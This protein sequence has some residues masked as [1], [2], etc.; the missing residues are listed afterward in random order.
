MKIIKSM[1]LISGLISIIGLWGCGS[2][3]SSSTPEPILK[4]ISLS[5]DYGITPY[6]K[7]N[8]YTKS[9]DSIITHVG[10]KTKV[11]A[12]GYYSDGSVRDITNSAKFKVSQR[13]KA[14]FD[15][16]HFIAKDAGEIEVWGAIGEVE[17]QIYSVKIS[18]SNITSISIAPKS[19]LIS[20]IDGYVV[21]KDSVSE[22]LLMAHFDDDTSQL[23][24]VDDDIEW[25]FDDDFIGKIED[26]K[27]S[28][29]NV[30]SSHL[31]ASF[32]GSTANLRIL[33]NDNENL[34]ELQTELPTELPLFGSA[35]L[36]ISAIYEKDNELLDNLYNSADVLA[37]TEWA[38][39]ERSDEF[40][41][42]VEFSNGK[43][44]AKKE[45]K[46][47]IVAKALGVATVHEM[48]I[49]DPILKEITIVNE[50][51]VD[52]VPHGLTI[53]LKAL[54]EFEGYESLVDVT[55]SV[56]WEV[57]GDSFVS[58]NDGFFKAVLPEGEVDI[59]AKIS[60]TTSKPIKLSATDAAVMSINI[61]ESLDKKTGV[62]SLNMSSHIFKVYAKLSDERE[63]DVTTN[64]KW[65]TSEKATIGIQRDTAIAWF[66][67]ISGESRYTATL[68][69]KR[70]E[71]VIKRINPICED[72]NN[73]RDD[74]IVVLGYGKSRFMSGPV[75]YSIQSMY[76]KA[77]YVV[78]DKVKNDNALYGPL[79]EFGLMSNSQGS[80][81]C[82][83]LA[84]YLW[85]NSELKGQQPTAAEMQDFRGF[86][87][88]AID[89]GLKR[90]TANL[91]FYSGYRSHSNWNW[92]F[93]ND[94][95]EYAVDY[96]NPGKDAT[97]MCQFK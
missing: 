12:K 21:P 72:N 66:G 89:K 60:T 93:V 78:K 42:D 46:V 2:D 37:F 9:A 30:G 50:Q 49:T 11:N 27:F 92:Y 5:L 82:A 35:E 80:D 85:E 15:G 58:L 44:V 38:I 18:D 40:R 71:F 16:N 8:L 67:G 43:L 91:G 26:G 84:G 94:Q 23:V 70:A 77:G 97:V 1:A 73:P 19:S 52:S 86:Y 7:G 22:W 69:D 45:G 59:V 65:N 88:S 34:L 31:R 87:Q 28:A 61:V 13:D 32:K 6:G 24:D 83:R 25:T 96:T 95:S 47:K 51:E 54:A 76:V 56:F 39:D 68:A 48:T 75:P 41:G 90:G 62:E 17:S 4:D 10:M 64:V 33:V 79:V 63:V 29:L 36:V 74:C 14:E 81:L 55:N 3:S 20:A 57:N 53:E